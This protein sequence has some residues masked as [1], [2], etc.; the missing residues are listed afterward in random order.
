M[1]SVEGSGTFL[2]GDVL[3]KRLGYGA[4]QLSGPGIF[5]PPR[6][7]EDRIHSLLQNR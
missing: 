4:M 5:G 7:P 6:D 2:L 1:S 3:V